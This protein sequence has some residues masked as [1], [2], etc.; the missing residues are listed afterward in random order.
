MGSE[1]DFKQFQP[2]GFPL[3]LIMPTFSSGKKQITLPSIVDS[4]A[5]FCTISMSIGKDALG[6]DFTRIAPYEVRKEWE[7][8]D[9]GKTKQVNEMID[10]IIKEKHVI[11]TFYECACGKLTKAFY[12]PVTIAFGRFKK[13]ILVLWTPAE[14]QSLLGRTGIFD[15][16]K[17]LVFKKGK[18]F[19]FIFAESKN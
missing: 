6:I 5:D 2:K 15:A 9:K 13:E 3:P 1:I 4:G 16:V 18:T 19:E 14:M 8:L 10:K 7:N 12:Y 11:P 17:E